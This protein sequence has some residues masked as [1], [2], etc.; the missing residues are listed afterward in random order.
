MTSAAKRCPP[1][2]TPRCICSRPLL[3]PNGHS[4][5]SRDLLDHLIPRCAFS[6]F[7]R[8]MSESGSDSEVGARLRVAPTQSLA[9]SHS[10]ACRRGQP[11]LDLTAD[12]AERI[13]QIAVQ[14]PTK[15]P[16]TFGRIIWTMVKA[17]LGAIHV[18]GVALDGD[19]RLSARRSRRILMA[20]R[21]LSATAQGAHLDSWSCRSCTN[22]CRL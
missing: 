10:V 1:V 12:Q 21:T 16:W 11:V 2:I 20:T 6:K 9:Q 17:I 15:S 19:V 4:K 5:R 8:G 7:Q 3:A 22:R 18:V 13:R 14:Q